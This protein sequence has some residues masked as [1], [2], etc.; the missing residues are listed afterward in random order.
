MNPSI[1]T[2]LEYAA[3][4]AATAHS[5]AAQIR[6]VFIESPLANPAE[7]PLA[8]F[9]RGGRGGNVRLKLYLSYL[10]IGAAPPHG[11]TR[12]ARAWAGLLGLED[13]EVRG[14]RRIA[15]AN[16]WLNDHRFVILAGAPGRAPTVTLLRE[17]GSGRPYELPGAVLTTKRQRTSAPTLGDYYIQLPATFWTSGWIAALSTAAVAMLLVLLSELAGRSAS[18]TDLWFSQSQADRRFFL[19]NETRGAGLRELTRLGLVAA[20]RQSITRGLFDF[21]RVRNVYRFN[22]DALNDGPPD[23]ME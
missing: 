13:P 7:P 19:S 8:R 15:D 9:L 6:R 2:A 3:E 5:R 22:P 21:R 10:W 12:P 20:R 23:M 17:D 14:A 18:D 1:E 16:R 11:I 4:A